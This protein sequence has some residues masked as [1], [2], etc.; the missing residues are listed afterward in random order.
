MTLPVVAAAAAFARPF[1]DWVARNRRHLGTVERATGAM[2]LVFVALIVTGR[3]S[4]VAEALL[5]LGIREATLRQ[6]RRPPASPC[7]TRPRAA[8]LKT[9]ARIVISRCMR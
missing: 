4:W 9:H 6:K 2:R 7:D 3:V 8:G 5:R 1:L